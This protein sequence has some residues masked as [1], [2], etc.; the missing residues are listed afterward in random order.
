[1][2]KSTSRIALVLAVTLVAISGCALKP[3]KK[4]NSFN[5]LSGDAGNP[6]RD[7]E[8]Q[9]SLARLSERHGNIQQAKS[10]YEA[11]LTKDDKNALAHQR[12]A[13]VAANE[14]QMNLADYH[15]QQALGCGEPNPELL[16]DYGYLLYLQHRPNDAEEMLRQAITKDPTNKAARNNLG[17]VLGEQGRFQESFAQFQMA[18]ETAA[19]HANL[20]YVYSLNGE[21]DLAEQEYHRAL[22]IDGDL[23]NAA[24]ALLQLASRPK[25]R[26]PPPAEVAA[27][28]YHQPSAVAGMPSGQPPMASMTA[29]GRL[30]EA[31]GTS[32]IE[33]QTSNTETNRG[34]AAAAGNNQRPPVDIRQAE[35]DPARPRK[36]LAELHGQPQ[37]VPGPQDKLGGATAPQSPA[38]AKVI[39]AP[40]TAPRSVGPLPRGNTAVP[41]NGLLLRQPT[42]IGPARQ[43][44]P[45]P[46]AQTQAAVPFRGVIAP[47]A[48]VGAASMRLSLE[49]NRNVI[50][51]S[52]SNSGLQ[53]PPA[54]DLQLRQSKPVAAPTASMRPTRPPEAK[55]KFTSAATEASAGQPDRSQ[56]TGLRGSQPRAA[57]DV[58]TR[59]ADRSSVFVSP[60]SS[61]TS[62]W[63][64]QP[65]FATPSQ[66]AGQAAPHPSANPYHRVRP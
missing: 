63:T 1:M 36:P 27:V 12:L 15:F 9:L 33:R 5:G 28:R 58:T 60:T 24:E 17:L 39:A 47:A 11:V 41:Q 8:A 54:A 32:D 45:P 14:R 46:A 31:I 50:A 49:E 53:Q 66:A 44:T 56:A 43:A 57:R 55:I 3:W 25:R 48:R 19:A 6:T 37:P 29:R 10:I 61:S 21:L 30:P 62:P 13:V 4:S 65:P 7:F 42:S 35:N 40:T 34:L 20:A 18:G 52:N 38:L 2:H 26:Q 59:M 16:S 64:W 51:R 22:A 23:R